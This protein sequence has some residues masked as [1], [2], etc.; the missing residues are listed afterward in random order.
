M[1]F[2]FSQDTRYLVKVKTY[3]GTEMLSNVT[4]N[5]KAYSNHANI[6]YNSCKR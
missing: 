1:N 5:M 3:N 4:V 2:Q 6:L